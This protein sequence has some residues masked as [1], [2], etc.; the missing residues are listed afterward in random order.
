MLY[1]TVNK[2]CESTKFKL[3]LPLLIIAFSPSRR[4]HLPLGEAIAPG[5]PHTDDEIKFADLCAGVSLKQGGGIGIHC[6]ARLGVPFT[7][8]PLVE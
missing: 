6:A 7:R 5:S 2:A 1:Q 4:E 3:R 8:T